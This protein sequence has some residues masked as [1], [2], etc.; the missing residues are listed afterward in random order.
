MSFLIYCS[1]TV[2]G[3]YKVRD[4]IEAAVMKVPI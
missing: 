1:I 2:G 3:S 4:T